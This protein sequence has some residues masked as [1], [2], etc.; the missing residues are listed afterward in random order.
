MRRALPGGYELDDDPARIDVEAVYAFVSRESY[1]G[2]DRPR[3]LV[4]RAIAGSCRVLGLYKDGGQV[5]FARAV[6]DKAIV[7]YLADVYVLERHRGKGLGVELVREMVD[8]DMFVG[9]RWFLH[10]ADAQ[11]LYEKLGFGPEDA[12]YPPME[13][14]PGSPAGTRFPVPV[15]PPYFR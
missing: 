14:A 15:V 12:P 1:W 6:S 2:R 5:G 11:G 4:E 7:A 3:E 9:V 10:T 8:A 13:R